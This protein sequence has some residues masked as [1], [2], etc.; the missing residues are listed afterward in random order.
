VSCRLHAFL[1][2]VVSLLS[3]CAAPEGAP[4]LAPAVHALALQPLN[5]I[6]LTR[7]VDG[8]P[9]DFG[10]I[11]GMDWDR[12]RNVWYLL[13]DDRSQVAPARFYS[14]NITL[15][16]TGLRSVRILATHPLRDRDGSPWRPASQGGLPPDPEALRIDPRDG[17]LHW[18]S[19]GDR[20]LGIQPSVRQMDR[21]G[22]FIS[23]W[24]LPP[25]LRVHPDEEKGARDN[26]SLEGLAFARDGSALWL[27]MEAPLYEDGPA[28]TTSAG[29]LA[30]LTRLGR[31]GQVLAQYAYPLDA[32][33]HAGTGGRR[34][35]DN[36]ASEIL[37][38]DDGGFLVVERSGREETEGS[39]VFSVR[40]YEARFAGATDVKHIASLRAAAVTPM[41]KRLLLD[42]DPQG[43]GSPA[44]FEAAAWGPCL[45]R[46][47][48]SLVLAAD[49]NFAP[50]QTN[51]IAAF[52]VSGAFADQRCP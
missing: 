14:A 47:V 11:S 51:T 17:S 21:T 31:D 33:P 29:A 50:P 28:T 23:E 52:E 15:D 49:D 10:G 25:Q 2:V 22:A 4:K 6:D 27:A 38:I 32:I 12:E 1:I 39:F 40:L 5:S 19:E 34:R 45:A 20:K 16:A 48:A 36:G 42:L 26:L 41:A 3:G 35:S 18:S 24:S 7:G 44:N 43:R 8:V 13:S 30:R 9:A 37:A 46:G